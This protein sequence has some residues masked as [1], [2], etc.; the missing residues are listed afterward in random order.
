MLLGAPGGVVV[1]YEETSCFIVSSCPPCQVPSPSGGS[2]GVPGR[3]LCVGELEVAQEGVHVG[4][5]VLSCAGGPCGIPR[6]AT[7]DDN[8]SIDTLL[9]D[10]E[11][12]HAQT[13]KP[14]LPPLGEGTSHGGQ[15]DTIKQE[16]S[17]QETNHPTWRPEEHGCERP[18]GPSSRSGQA[19]ATAPSTGGERSTAS[20]AGPL[21]T[22]DHNGA[23]D[24]RSCLCQH[25]C[26]PFHVSRPSLH[27]ISRFFGRSSG[28]W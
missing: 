17:S 10:L 18:H 19:R 20:L 7:W 26:V 15:E 23:A 24:P 28:G 22:H 16:V 25:P 2:S 4:V 21:C 6:P 3:G 12:A 13:P 14:G 8:P 11:V 9:S 1:P 5:V 27:R